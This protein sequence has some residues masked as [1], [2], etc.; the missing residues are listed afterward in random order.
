M[1][2][3][4]KMILL[5]LTVGALLVAIILT[6]I[7]LGATNLVPWLLVAVLIAIPVLIRRR[8]KKYFVVWK[9]EYSVGVQVLDDDHRKLLSLI[10]KLQTTVHYQTGESFEKEALD[11][12]IAYT[13]YHFE[14]EEKLMEEANY[15]DLEAHKETHRS[16]ITKVDG[17]VKE[18]EKKGHEV[19][20]DVATYLKDWLINHINGTDQKYSALL[21]EK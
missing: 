6:F 8:E 15:P 10:N 19:L 14:R 18:Y 7:S 13:K 17:F 3:S 11:E 12:V 16:M 1:S 2:K 20:G 5:V 9:D 4:L 21:K